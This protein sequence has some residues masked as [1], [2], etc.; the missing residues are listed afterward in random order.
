MLRAMASPGW[1][2]G[3]TLAGVGAMATGSATGGCGADGVEVHAVNAAS[4]SNRTVRNGI[5]QCSRI[6]ATACTRARLVHTLI[7]AAACPNETGPPIGAHCLL[8]GSIRAADHKMAL[9]NLR[10]KYMQGTSRREGYAWY[11]GWSQFT[12]R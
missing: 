5:R 6:E 2:R 7:M 1:G 11:Q 3:C 8:S 9:Q 12:P 4:G 10:S